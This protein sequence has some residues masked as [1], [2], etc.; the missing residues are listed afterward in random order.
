MERAMSVFEFSNFM[1]AGPLGSEKYNYYRGNH[2]YQ[3]GWGTL[4]L[5]AH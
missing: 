5:L 3:S 2:N 1:L 4:Q